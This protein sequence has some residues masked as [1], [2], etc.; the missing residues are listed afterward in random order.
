MAITQ[1][2][3][4]MLKQ[5][6]VE[7]I[8]AGSFLPGDLLPSENELCKRF[9]VSR[10]TA[11][12]ALDELVS[13][14]IVRRERG[15]GTFVNRQMG[16]KRGNTIGVLLSYASDYIFPD[17]LCSIEAVLSRQGY[18]IDLGI[19]Y[20]N[21]NQERR[22]LERMLDANISG[23]LV[24]GTKSALPNPNLKYYQEFLHRDIPVVFFHNYYVQLPY[25]A[26]LMNDYDN[27]YRLTQMI[28]DHG[29]TS[30]GG[31]FM[32]DDLQGHMR[33]KGYVQAIMD[34]GLP[35]QDEKV[36]WFSTQNQ[37]NSLTSYLR[38]ELERLRQCTALVCYNDMTASQVY[39]LLHENGIRVPADIS[40]VGCDNHIKKL[41]ANLQLTTI[42]YPKKEVG[43]AAAGCLMEQVLSNACIKEQRITII[44]CEIVERASILTRTSDD[45]AT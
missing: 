37:R 36:W 19:T 7:Q 4:L 16:E 9:S 25:P 31:V 42:Q 14:G 5:W 30:I 21:L 29:H 28:I 2:K 18:G 32:L 39:T 34:A 27:F 40:M 23:L 15:S 35:V 12:N 11:R 3:Y 26:F 20:N 38:E 10:Q 33:Y 44:P 17:V 8:T 24:E 22:F 13:Q 43:N 6:I 41:N 1:F 45:E